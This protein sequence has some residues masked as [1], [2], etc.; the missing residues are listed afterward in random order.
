MQAVMTKVLLRACWMDKVCQGMLFGWKMAYDRHRGTERQLE[1]A[2]RSLDGARRS[3]YNDRQLL[4]EFRSQS[5]RLWDEMAEDVERLPDQLTE[6]EEEVD[7]VRSNLIVLKR[8]A[9]DSGESLL[10]LAMVDHQRRITF[11][12][13]EVEELKLSHKDALVEE[14]L[15]CTLSH[16]QSSQERRYTCKGRR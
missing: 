3:A 4:M 12:T 15:G 6:A 1:T 13:R 9:Y 16:R 8:Q 5:Q 7:Q 11:L 2:N 14:H 10:K